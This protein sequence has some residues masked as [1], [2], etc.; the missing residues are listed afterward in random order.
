MSIS[1]RYQTEKQL[2]RNLRSRIINTPFTKKV[3][4]KAKNLLG[5]KGDALRFVDINEPFL[6]ADFSLY[7]VKK[8]GMTPIGYYKKSRSRTRENEKIV[9]RA[10]LSSHTSLFE[11]KDRKE[12]NLV[13]LEDIIGPLGKVWVMEEK[14]ADLDKQHFIIF[15]RLL[16]FPKFHITSGILMLFFREERKEVIQKAK[17]LQNHIT[18]GPESQ[19]KYVAYYMLNRH[20][21]V[22]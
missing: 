19:R 12:K 2:E 20:H 15:T 5:I 13:M 4:E 17:N 9:L 7:E 16:P 22:W 1:K 14:F 21:G 11:I 3:F 10:M 8:K 6:F 18:Q